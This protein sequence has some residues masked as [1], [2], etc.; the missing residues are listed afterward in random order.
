MSG[1]DSSIEGHDNSKFERCW[2]QNSNSNSADWKKSN[3]QAKEQPRDVSNQEKST[4]SSEA[5][6]TTTSKARKKKVK[7]FSKISPADSCFGDTKELSEDGIGEF[8]EEEE[9]EEGAKIGQDEQNHQSRIE[10]YFTLSSP[11]GVFERS[12]DDE[13]VPMILPEDGGNESNGS[14]RKAMGASM[15]SSPAKKRKPPTPPANRNQKNLHGK[16][17]ISVPYSLEAAWT[18]AGENMKRSKTTTLTEGI[19][20]RDENVENRCSH[21]NDTSESS[22][23]NASTGRQPMIT[24]FDLFKNAN[25]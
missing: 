24:H 21:S 22:K 9:E 12:V 15:R 3:M 19:A 16:S 20:S 1:G 4:P 23:G 7:K 6:V 11:S 10:K 13:D 18:R 8:S 17:P 25:R 5:V 14:M 2:S